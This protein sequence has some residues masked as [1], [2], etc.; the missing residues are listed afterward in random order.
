MN[1][2]L[3]LPLTSFFEQFQSIFIHD[4]QNKRYET[5]NLAEFFIWLK[6]QEQLFSQYLFDYSSNVNTD[7]LWNTFLHLYKIG[8]IDT[9]FIHVITI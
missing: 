5:Q 3:N 1:R 2:Q 7:E 9:I 4:I 8:T 6:S